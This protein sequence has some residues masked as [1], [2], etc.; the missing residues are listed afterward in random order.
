MGK[1]NSFKFSVFLCKLAFHNA[2]DINKIGGETL[3]GEGI[4]SWIRVD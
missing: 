4:I 3:S 2:T 1:V